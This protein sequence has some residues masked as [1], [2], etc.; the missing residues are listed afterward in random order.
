[1]ISLMVCRESRGLRSFHYTIDSYAA[2]GTYYATCG[3]THAFFR[4]GREGEM[5]AAVVDLLGLEEQDVGRTSDHAQVTTFAAIDV[6][7][8]SAMYF[9]HNQ[10]LCLA[11]R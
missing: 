6:D 2:V 1:M 3:A 10:I 7:V 9:S 8:Y 4:M 11:V 5:I